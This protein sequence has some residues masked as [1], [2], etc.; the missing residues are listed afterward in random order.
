MITLQELYQYINDQLKVNLFDDYCPNGLQVEGANKITHLATAVSASLETI[1]QAVK[2]GAQ[3]LLVHHGI[4][5]NRDSY[6][7]A[8][9]KKKK[10]EA[11]L[12]NNI[13]LLAYHLPLDAHQEFGNNW[14]AAKEL[15][16]KNLQP[17][18][19]IKNVGLGVKGEVDLDAD[20][21][22]NSLEKY[23]QHQA[24]EAPGGKKNIRT[25]GLISGGS[26]KS[27]SDAAKENLD[28]FVTGSFDE[29]AWHIAQEEGINFYAM[30][31]SATEKIGV[32]T[33]GEHLAEKFGLKIT[34]IDVPNPF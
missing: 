7:I 26:Y 21:F 22:K 13:S 31:H 1:E 34:F 5:W 14:R 20:A 23:Y 28:A 27:I 8:G 17:F 4:F 16:W 11:L 33:L 6:V 25:A 32:K 29:P 10:I 18:L 15:G 3:A 19:L 2:S 30:G 9:V 24:H 12:K